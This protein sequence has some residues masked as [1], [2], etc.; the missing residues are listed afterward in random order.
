MVQSRVLAV[1]GL[2]AWLPAQRWYAAKGRSPVLR[3]LGGY[4]LDD[5]AGEVGIEVMVV[6]DDSGPA[7]VVYQV[8]LTYRGA[9]LA[10]AEGALVGRTEH[11]VLGTRWV[12]DGAHDPVFAG[13]LLEGMRPMEQVLRDS[14]Q[15]GP[16]VPVADD[17]PVVERL[18]GFVGRDPAW[19]PG[20]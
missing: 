14:G 3:S 4:R 9:P 8:P 17:A 5:P 2:A 11:G 13:Q 16:A 12:Y 7:P 18:M 19:R 15:Y 10:G 1:V 6:A 20:S